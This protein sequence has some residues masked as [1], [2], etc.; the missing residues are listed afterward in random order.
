MEQF[1]QRNHTKTK[2]IRPYVISALILLTS[3]VSNG[4]QRVVD[5][6]IL[7]TKY[8]VSVELSEPIK[9]YLLQHGTRT[10]KTNKEFL[11]FKRTSD[12]LTIIRE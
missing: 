7:T 1:T 8:F 6:H 9:F 10:L 5:M 2:G 4:P 11:V 12:Y 3:C